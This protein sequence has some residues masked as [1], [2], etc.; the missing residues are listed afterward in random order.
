MNELT[1]SVKWKYIL[2]IIAVIVL[3]LAN[4]VEKPH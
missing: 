2:A 3:A 4:P 1:K